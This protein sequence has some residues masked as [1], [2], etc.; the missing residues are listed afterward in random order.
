MVDNIAEEVENVGENDVGELGE[1]GKEHNA[2]N[3]ADSDHQEIIS[4]VSCVILCL[5][6]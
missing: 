4:P 5:Y 1:S 6:R 2:D 3:N